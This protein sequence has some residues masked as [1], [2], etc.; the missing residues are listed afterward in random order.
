MSGQFNC[1]DR[2]KVVHLESDKL[3]NLYNGYDDV[4]SMLYAVG[5]IKSI[6]NPG[7]PGARYGIEFDE[8]YAQI[9]RLRTGIIFKD[10]Q[11]KLVND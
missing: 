4:T 10:H 1:G 3:M 8:D 9:L 7:Q 5:E 2:V 6:S 11:L